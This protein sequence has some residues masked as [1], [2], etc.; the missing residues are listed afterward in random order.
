M[1]C[2]RVQRRRVLVLDIP[3]LNKCYQ[4]SLM[5]RGYGI[6]QRRIIAYMSRKSDSHGSID[7]LCQFVY[8]DQF[9]LRPT[10]S[11]PHWGKL[12]IPPAKHRLASFVQP[13]VFEQQVFQ[14]A[15]C[16]LTKGRAV[17]YIS[18]AP[19]ML[20]LGNMR[21]YAADRAGQH[22][23]IVGAG[24]PLLGRPAHLS[25]HGGQI[26]LI[27][28]GGIA[29]LGSHRN[30]MGFTSLSPPSLRHRLCCRPSPRPGNGNS[31][32]LGLSPSWATPMAPKGG[33]LPPA[34]AG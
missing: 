3:D 23:V 7:G 15:G 28:R 18:I 22:D 30:V 4:Y 6:V 2:E 21:R 33:T 12:T 31:V 5:S 32:R 16:V 8:G 24:L 27:D 26:C 34:A 13:S 1:L 11:S 14:P 20:N 25:E 19:T 29:C 17:P 9:Y 10:K